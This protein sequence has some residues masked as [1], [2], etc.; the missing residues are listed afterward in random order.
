MLGQNPSPGTVTIGP[1][2]FTSRAVRVY[3]CPFTVNV[4]LLFP[5]KSPACGRAVVSLFP[6][7]TSSVPAAGALSAPAPLGGSGAPGSYPALFVTHELRILFFLCRIE[8]L[9]QS[10]RP[11]VEEMIREMGVGQAAVEQLAIYCV[12]LKK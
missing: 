8:L 11:E 12:S 2:M 4:A 5:R 7:T 1:K 10:Q 9:L 3:S 6:R